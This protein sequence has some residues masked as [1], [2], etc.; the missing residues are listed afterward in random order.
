MNTKID[1]VLDALMQDTDAIKFWI[2]E[3]EITN[4]E[5]DQKKECRACNTEFAGAYCPNC[6]YD[7]A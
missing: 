2:T 1:T 5:P 6:G 3:G 7:N 4:A